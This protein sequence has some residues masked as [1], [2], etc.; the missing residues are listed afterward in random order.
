DVWILFAWLMF[1]HSLLSE[2]LIG[3]EVTLPCRAEGY[4]PLELMEWSRPGTHLQYVVI[5]R[6]QS[7][8]L[9]I[10][11]QRYEGRVELKDRENGDVSLV[12]KNVTAEDGGTY[13]CYVKRDTDRMKRAIQPV[14]TIYLDVLPPP[15]LGE[16]VCLWIRTSSSF[17]ILNAG[18]F[19]NTRINLILIKQFIADSQW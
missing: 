9:E 6:T 12:L 15:P 8:D 5:F 19:F 18:E 11:E 7:Q 14:S 16:S 1:L 17:L 4:M 10:P 3:G 13:E 2:N